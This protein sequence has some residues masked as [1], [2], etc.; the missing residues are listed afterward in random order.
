MG[1]R[2]NLL[3]FV[4]NSSLRRFGM[5][6]SVAILAF[7][8]LPLLAQRQNFTINVGTPEGQQLQAIGQEPDQAKKVTLME[9][10]L[11]KYPKHEGAPWVAGQLETIYLQ[12]KDY[13]K[14]LAA[15]DKAYTG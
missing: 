12:Q 5:K 11:A 14:A 2:F 7:F 9:D 8:V 15:A 4:L 13:D 3:S 10:F 1:G 6:R